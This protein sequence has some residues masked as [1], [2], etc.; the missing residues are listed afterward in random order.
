MSS[1]YDRDVLEAVVD[2]PTP[3]RWRR[4]AGAVT[5]AAVMFVL[6]VVYV[7]V[8]RQYPGREFVLEGGPLLHGGFLLGIVAAW[9]IGY[10]VG[11]ALASLAW[12]TPA[13]RALMAAE[14]DGEG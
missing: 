13:E 4:A 10:R 11:S 7:D 14:D 12:L 1:E 8:V 2:D 9:Y 5:V 6:T 3:P